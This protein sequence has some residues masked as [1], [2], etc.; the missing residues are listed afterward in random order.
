MAYFGN[1]STGPKAKTTTNFGDWQNNLPTYQSQVQQ[2]STS[3]L[4]A[5][6][7]K[8][9]PA[10]AVLK[11]NIWQS[12]V[13]YGRAANQGVVDVT[14]L[15][16]GGQND[17][18]AQQ[19]QAQ[20]AAKNQ[21]FIT[22]L[23]KQGKIK[24]P[25]AAKII[26]ANAQSGSKGTTPNGIVPAAKAIGSGIIQD[27]KMIYN[28]GVQQFK[29]L[30]GPTS[31]Q[32]E[33]DAIINNQSVAAKATKAG[34]YN[35]KGSSAA[36]QIKINSMIAKGASKKDVA[37]TAASDKKAYDNN[38]KQ[39]VGAAVELASLAVGGGGAKNILKGGFRAGA[40][41]F[42][43]TA[44]ANT[45]AG[46]AGNAGSTILENPNAS[47]KEIVKSA[48]QGGAAAGALSVA[49]KVTKVAND[50]YVGRTQATKD[51]LKTRIATN[52]TDAGRAANAPKKITVKDLSSG[53]AT[54]RVSTVRRDTTGIPVQSSS[55]STKINVKAPKTSGDGFTMAS[56]ADKTDVQ[57]SARLTEINQKLDVYATGKSRLAPAEAK[58]LVK[59]RSDIKAGAANPK[60]TVKDLKTQ[61]KVLPA[62]NP[63]VGKKI[64]FNDLRSSV[65]SSGKGPKQIGVDKDGDP[66]FA[67]NQTKTANA[68]V[69][70]D[71][72]EQGI[73]KPT[74]AK[75]AKEPVKLNSE[76]NFTPK[77]FKE[78][79]VAAPSKSKYATNPL[80]RLSNQGHV[81]ATKAVKAVQATFTSQARK[82]QAAVDAIEKQMKVDGIK[83]ADLPKI[84]ESGDRSTKTA[85]MLH[86]H[87]D[88]YKKDLGDLKLV[89][90]LKENYFPRHAQFDSTSNTVK[91][92]FGLSKKSTNTKN[93]VQLDTTD[94]NGLP[95]KTDK[96]ATHADFVKGVTDQGG[97]TLTPL[98]SLRQ[99]SQNLDGNIRNGRLIESLK[100][101]AMNDGRAAVIT[102][103]LPQPGYS[104]VQEFPGHQVH[105]DMRPMVETLSHPGSDTGVGALDAVG[106]I[107]SSVKRLVT[108]NALVHGKNF[109]I[110]D[111]RNRG[112]KALIPKTDRYVQADVQRAV[113]AGFEPFTKEN[114]QTFDGMSNKHFTGKLGGTIEKLRGKS[115]SALF[116]RF[117]NSR[118][119]HTF[120]SVEKE[121]TRMQKLGLVDKNLS[122]EEISQLAAKSAKDTMMMSSPL[123][124]SLDNRQ[125]SRIGFFAGQFVQNTTQLVTK[126][127]GLGT[128]KS[129]TKGAQKAEQLLAV[130]RLVRGSA[131][132]FTAA[133]ALNYSTT[134]R[135]TWEN[136]GSKVLPV[137]YVDKTGKEYHLSNFY[138]QLGDAYELLHDTKNFAAKKTSPALRELSSIVS[139]KDS[140]G[141]DV[142]DKTASGPR[143]TAQAFAN[144]ISNFITPVGVSA[145]DAKGMING[146][147]KPGAVNAAR[148]FGYGASSKDQN[149][150]DVTVD[151][152]Y[153]AQFGSRTISDAEKKISADKKQT[154]SDIK[155]GNKN[156]PAVNRVKGAISET[157]FTKFMKGDYSKS[158]TQDHFDKL[159]NSEDKLKVVEE[160]KPNELKQID[161]TSL[162]STLTKKDSQQR[163]NGLGYDNARI[164]KVI[165]K[166]GYSNDKL[167]QLFKQNKVNK[168]TATAASRKARGSGNSQKDSVSYN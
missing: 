26:Q 92:A 67:G 148:L 163:L 141:N 103:K 88:G 19:Q 90:G 104:P 42:T 123:E 50:R 111:I 89:D 159:Q 91:R 17:L 52:A 134:G 167:N 161:L 119:M 144:A 149:H 44:V 30:A 87:L 43:K 46:A 20:S 130:K 93:R 24:Q 6:A 86:D 4:A 107:N 76:G 96:Y 129:L 15:L 3:R 124:R 11:P 28:K 49:G 23:K 56:K 138:G 99:M 136:R 132:M 105:D 18:K 112:L 95:T 145:T 74:T 156:S 157:S 70:S 126:A 75:A 118:G 40:K 168:K 10:P 59:E 113:D 139:N 81:A 51:F 57:R 53:T 31:T 8:T 21:K 127:I 150:T 154:I 72:I 41:Q 160:L 164:A 34:K 155:S 71:S 122:K 131:Y 55:T 37:A 101:T 58:A 106:K 12:I 109:V 62:K 152:Y 25:A 94:A 27:P 33:R 1:S 54:G 151:K 82:S 165:Q 65:A 66:I 5:P 146:T 166:A 16:P 137:F 64:T 110:A 142:T 73:S 68:N 102:D 39:G 147:G 133:Q 22:D 78:K 13:H 120:M 32:A 108:Y 128:D 98:Q 48:V 162:M 36:G 29:H 9:A 7:P 69:E 153:Q 143:Q 114:I 45:V 38:T 79:L 117:G 61:T 35:S 158:Q 97:K 116:E 100:T 140:L 125:I 60:V 135:P 2:S 14:R 115:D 121:L 84:R 85:Q 63:I 47:K 83:E 80:I 77:T